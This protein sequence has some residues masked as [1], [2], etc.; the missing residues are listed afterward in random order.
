M[1]LKK[2]WTL[3]NTLGPKFYDGFLQA[4]QFFQLMRFNQHS[5]YSK[6]SIHFCWRLLYVPTIVVYNSSVTFHSL[7]KNDSYRCLLRLIWQ[8]ILVCNKKF[9]WSWLTPNS[10]NILVEWGVI[11]TIGIFWDQDFLFQDHN[12]FQYKTNQNCNPRDQGP[13][14]K[15]YSTENAFNIF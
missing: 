15:D 12:T 11:A 1:D 4:F 10:L 6:N 7:F 2:P 8:L 14:L 3:K 13:C 5:F 9:E